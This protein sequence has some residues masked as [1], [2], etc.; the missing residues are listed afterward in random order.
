MPNYAQKTGKRL[1]FQPGFFEYG[2]SP[3]FASAARKYD[4]YFRYP[5]SEQDTIEIEYPK[6][7][8]LDNADS[9]GNISDPQKIGSLDIIIQADRNNALLIY[10]RKFH[11]G[12]G[13]NIL[14]PAGLYQPLKNMFDTFHKADSHT[15]TLRQK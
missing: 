13:G 7:F 10:N 6:T 11:F 15:I 3:V 8:D 9:P 5:W 1:F 2:T 12:G 4:V 14:F